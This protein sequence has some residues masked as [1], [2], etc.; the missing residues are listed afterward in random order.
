MQHSS[1]LD[2]LDRRFP[3]IGNSFLPDAE[4]RDEDKLPPRRRAGRFKSSPGFY[5]LNMQ[6][7]AKSKDMDPLNAEGNATGEMMLLLDQPEPPSD[8]CVLAG[9]WNDLE[10]SSPKME[11]ENPADFESSA[12][13]SKQC[14][15]E[16]NTSVSAAGPTNPSHANTGDFGNST[17]AETDSEPAFDPSGN[18]ASIYKQSYI[19]AEKAQQAAL[20]AQQRRERRFSSQAGRPSGA[21]PT[22]TSPVLLGRRGADFAK[23]AQSIAALQEDSL[24]LAKRSHQAFL[25][26]QQRRAGRHVNSSNQSSDTG[27]SSAWPVLLGHSSSNPPEDSRIQ[28]KVEHVPDEPPR[29]TGANGEQWISMALERSKVAL[30][31]QQRRLDR[32][33][34]APAES[35]NTTDTQTKALPVL[36]N[37]SRPCASAHHSNGKADEVSDVV[38]PAHNIQVNAQIRRSVGTLL[39]VLSSALL[40]CLQTPRTELNS[41]A[42]SQ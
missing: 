5:P 14:T 39:I 33:P 27:K 17:A 2:H 10:P 41:W 38:Q 24:S 34:D 25:A 22:A 30:A 9:V 42:W 21:T 11:L 4:K 6:V 18:V 19:L 1:S 29:E 31:S 26:S 35:V 32:F 28:R 40:L 7:V 15:D 20:A 36:L 12:N 23:P 3:P 8:G 13:G 37:S 16:T